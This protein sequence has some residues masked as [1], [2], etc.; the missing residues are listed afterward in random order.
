MNTKDNVHKPSVEETADYLAKETSA[1][2]EKLT[3][4]ERAARLAAFKRVVASVS[5]KPLRSAGSAR[6]RA[7]SRGR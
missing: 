6:S 7:G 1:D 2:L 3:P 5:A 4:E